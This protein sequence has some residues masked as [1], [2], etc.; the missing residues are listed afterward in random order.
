[1][2]T[3]VGGRSSAS[4]N[5]GLADAAALEFLGVAFLTVALLFLLNRDTCH[6]PGGGGVADRH[7]FRAEFLLWPPLLRLGDVGKSSS[8]V[9]CAPLFHAPSIAD[10]A[11]S[12]IAS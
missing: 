7:L 2:G 1:M 4:P 9:T 3:A 10:V 12:I 11:C 5:S 6:S 8:G